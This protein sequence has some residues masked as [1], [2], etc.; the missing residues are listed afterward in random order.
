MKKLLIAVAVAC[1]GTTLL[2]IVASFA[3]AAGE[4]REDVIRAL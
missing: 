1:L 4:G 3:V 2:S